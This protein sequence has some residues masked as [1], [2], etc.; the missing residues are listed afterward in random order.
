MSV[1]LSATNLSKTYGVR[2]L[3]TGISIDLRVG[4][5]VGL[6]GPNGSGKSTLLKLLTGLETPDEGEVAV[7][8]TVRLA[9]LAQE[10]EFDPERTVEEV[11]HDALRDDPAEEHEKTTR[12]R[13][14]LGKVGFSSRD[15]KFGSLSGGWKKRVALACEFAK[16]PDLLILDEPTNHLDLEGILWLEEFLQDAPFAYVVVSH[17]RYF[18]ENVT[19]QVIEFDRVYPEGYLRVEG[20][21]S[22]FLTRREEFLA[23]QAR[24]EQSL[25]SKVRREVEWLKRGA[26]A[27]TGKSNARIN[28]ANRLIGDLQDIRSRNAPS[29]SAGIDFAATGR[30]SKKLIAVKNV[31]KAMGGKP[32]F[33]DLEFMLSPGNKFGLL[34][35]NGSGKT[36]LL[37]LLTGETAPDAGVIERAEGLRVVLFDQ[38]RR[39]LDRTVTLRRALSPNSEEV[40]FGDRTYH[41][42]AW[43]KRFLFRVEQM[44]QMVGDL[45]GGEQA[46]VLIARMM[47]QP[48]DVLLL[49]EP[50]NDLDLPTLEVLEE[51]LA[52]FSGALVLVTHDR[53][54]LDRLCTELVGLDGRGNAHIYA[55]FS[56]WIAAQR[57]LKELKPAAAPKAGKPRDKSRKLSYQEQ[58]EFD[59]ME[60]R[61]LTAEETVMARQQEADALAGGDHVRLQAAYQA[62]HD[63]Q[64]EVDR[65]YHRW[66]ELEAKRG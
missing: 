23:G 15:Q 29:S 4:E 53:A 19:N 36:T 32:L 47:V 8:R 5:R 49:D 48:A 57:E 13:I 40:Q 20:S 31:A 58:R 55:D 59:G 28:E 52:E 64:A 41:V 46:R 61:I 43:A 50:T 45:S 42:T 51:S 12:I 7:R 30:R 17:D 1:L 37:R 10:A 27:R 18:L 2:P 54:M 35:P 60:E 38:G 65:L 62:V 21:Y 14:T 16:Q 44:D 6:I 66:Q 25:S 3:F 56:Q 34:G 22:V 39:Q 9:Y 26:R 24:Q 63:A 11:V 33:S